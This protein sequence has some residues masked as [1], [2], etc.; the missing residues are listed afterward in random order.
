MYWVD[1]TALRFCLIR[2]YHVNYLFLVFLKKTK[3]EQKKTATSGRDGDDNMTA[4]CADKWQI[5][6]KLFDRFVGRMKI[7]RQLNGI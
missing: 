2:E 5:F 3:S 7:H 6:F 4:K 1:K